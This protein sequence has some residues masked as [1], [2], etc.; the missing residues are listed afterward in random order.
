MTRKVRLHIDRVVLDGVGPANP[1]AFERA[2]RRKLGEALGEAHRA[3]T[4]DGAAS[5]AKI[6]GGRLANPADPA[7]LGG[8]V[9]ARLTR[10]GS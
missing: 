3:G 7:A 8:R 2:L 4:L 1:L 6:D 5:A 10:G 9:A